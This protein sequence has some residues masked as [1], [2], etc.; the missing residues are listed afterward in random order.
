MAR[1]TY[2]SGL[3]TQTIDKL[4][5]ACD[6][7]DNTNVDIKKGIDMIYNA[8]G[9]ENINIDFTPI[10]GFQ[11]SV[12]EYIETM[13]TEIS[14]KA[15][16][17]EEY[18]S[19][20]WYK[21]L[22]STIGMGALKIVEGLAS[23]VE[24][25]GD[26]LVSVA[27]FV[28][29]VFSSDFKESVA[30]FVKTDY[31]G[32]TT[33][34]W[35]EEGWLQNVNKYSAMS[36]ESTAANV[37]KGIGVATGYVIVGVATGGAGTAGLA[38]SA[39]AAAL[40]GIGSGTQTGLQAGKTFNQAFGQG[41]K[42]GAIAAGTTLLAAGAVKGLSNAATSL[43]GSEGVIKVF[44]KVAENTDDMGRIAKAAN[45]VKSMVNTAAN[46]ALNNTVGRAIINGADKV[47]TGAGNAIDDVA[48]A[49][50]DKTGSGV[51]GTAIAKGAIKVTENSGAIIANTVGGITGAVTSGQ[52]DNLQQSAE[53]RIQQENI[54]PIGGG[55]ND[56]PDYTPTPAT[57]EQAATNLQNLQNLQNNGYNTGTTPA[58]SAATN[59]SNTSGGTSSG[60][61]TSNGGTYNPSTST[62]SSSTPSSSTP[63]SSTPS[64][65]STSTN[66]STPSSTDT[67]TTV[68]NP[69]PGTP[70]SNT[71]NTEDIIGNVNIGGDTPSGGNP[72]NGNNS[73][74]SSTIV[75]GGTALVNEAASTTT[76][77]KEVLDTFG[78]ATSS[79]SG[80]S[81]SKTSIPTSSSPILSSDG[82]ASKSIIPL[83]AGLGAAAI[84]GIG[85]KTI[86]EKKN[87]SSE[88]EDKLETEEWS[89][90][91]SM[92]I[93][94]GQEETD[95]SDY[96]SPTDE[97][98][99]QE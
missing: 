96:L 15:Q 74:T 85:A 98:A 2:N 99:F 43:K 34:K 71:T 39:G 58:T 33:A 72:S 91:D 67:V 77:S 5:S 36:H 75:N 51:I 8:R 29:G 97:Y 46:K 88:K 61:G 30:E 56:I 73:G 93:D 41:V 95:Q 90:S 42:Q 52:F 28:G 62:P 37:L 9:A 23:F 38:A 25:I 11:S 17:I 86:I 32:E 81:G 27:G 48:G 7:L 45:G 13:A 10:I 53:F 59:T 84:A 26:G 60:G 44:S 16:E 78:N 49:V 94:Y 1:Y 35:Y 82:G 40:G 83:G 57:A 63:S 31:V 89:E 68:N 64:S 19:A 55:E 76:A 65:S 6:S 87:N 80:I 66:P 4:Y 70:P 92:E 18:Q 14:A 24:Q 69:K 50:F 20:P 54:T 22:F 21:K 12:V 3:V 79:L 47:L